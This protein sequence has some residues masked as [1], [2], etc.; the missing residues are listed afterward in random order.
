MV[1]YRNLRTV[2][3]IVDAAPWLT[4]G[5]LRWWIFHAET[6]GMAPAIFKVGKRVFIDE[7]RFNKWLESRQG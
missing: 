4:E 2:K 3:Q 7:N 6:N 1:D 5:M